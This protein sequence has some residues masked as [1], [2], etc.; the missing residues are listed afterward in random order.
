MHLFQLIKQV[1]D[2]YIV[3]YFKGFLFIHTCKK[4]IV[5]GANTKM[6]L[7]I[8]PKDTDLLLKKK[9]VLSADVL[10]K[11]RYAGEITQT[12]LSY[13]IS[14]INDSYH[15]GKHE[16]YSAAELCLLGD[17]FIQ[18]LVNSKYKKVIEK[19]IA[20]P[21]TLD[22]NDM[23][24][25]YSPELT[26][27]SNLTFQPGDIVTINLGCQIDGYTSNLAHTI[28]IYP[29]GLTAPTGPLLGGPADAVC[30]SY[31]ATET[32]VSLLAC[33]LSPEKIP[34]SLLSDNSNRHITGSMIRKVVDTIA[35]SFNCAIVPT[36]KV[37][38]IRRFLAGQA[39]GVVAE[40]DFKGVV[41]SEIDQESDLLKRS[42]FQDGSA[43]AS[44]GNT[45]LSIIDQ[46][47]GRSDIQN[48][49]KAIPTDDFVVSAGEVYTVDIKMAPIDKQEPGLVTVD[50]GDGRDR[51]AKHSIFIR[52]VS[53]SE[54][55]KLRNSRRLLSLVDK[56][57]SVYPFKLAYVSESFPLDSK[58]DLA[59]QLAK[60]E[61]DVKIFRFGLTECTNKQLFVPKAVLSCK[62]IPLREVLKV[63]TSTGINGFDA[64]NP[65]LPGMEL[66]LPKLG[67]TALKLKTLLKHG[68]PVTVSRFLSTVALSPDAGCVRLSGGNKTFTP[69]WVHS[70]YQLQ[71]PVAAA[72]GELAAL[73]QD[74]R[75]GLKIDEC[76]VMDLSA[77]A[78][79]DDA[80]EE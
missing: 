30:A 72:V 44:S 40:R 62:F 67:L 49:D 29:S 45:D 25:G 56:E 69:S 60:I 76:R 9:N 65:A 21:V 10:D 7:Q 42:N 73:V 28:V 14:L 77:V 46:T 50:S 68:R 5:K 61:K 6:A 74:E 20:Q 43:S 22:V 79:N 53:M 41:W 15:L 39:E 19:G 52:D 55:L 35:Q 58:K 17:S 48:P 24:V 37:R 75:F 34:N 33:A 13:L 18:T 63:P 1:I 54:Q 36:S 26:D 2:L 80:M 59:E 51:G 66:P 70:D 12:C 47:K 57:Q 78:A 23:I 32:V 27:E 31:L 8:S 38:R 11:Y 71:G 3:F 64:S 4:K 16:P